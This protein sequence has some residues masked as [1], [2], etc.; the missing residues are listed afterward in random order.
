M[1][2][3]FF[4]AGVVSA[5]MRIDR[6]SFSDNQD[7]FGIYKGIGEEFIALF[8]FANNFDNRQNMLLLSVAESAD[9]VELGQITQ[10]E[11]HKLSLGWRSSDFKIRVRVDNNDWSEWFDSQ[12]SWGEDSFGVRITMPPAQDYGD[13]YLANL[14]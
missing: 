3:G 14:W 9:T 13:F 12:T 11:W 4:E 7:L 6:N 1:P 8:R 2:G 5:E 10:R